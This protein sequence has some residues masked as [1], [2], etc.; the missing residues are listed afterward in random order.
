MPE[1]LFDITKPAAVAV[2]DK[3]AAENRKLR[4]ALGV[5]L[6]E[7]DYT[8]GNCRVNEMVGAVLSRAA[9]GLAREALK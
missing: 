8:R 3:L 6:D 2:A 7:T 4:A 1:E 5:I 9:I